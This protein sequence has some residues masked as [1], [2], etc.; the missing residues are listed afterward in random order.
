MRFIVLDSGNNII[1]ITSNT[2]DDVMPTVKRGSVTD[3]VEVPLTTAVYED[4]L[5]KIEGKDLQSVDMHFEPQAPTVSTSEKPS[6]LT[7][8]TR[9]SLLRF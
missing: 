7:A 8:L 1:E 6:W 9:I 4:Y 3:G 2:T 5:S